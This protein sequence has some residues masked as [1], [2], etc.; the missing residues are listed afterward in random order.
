ML[1]RRRVPESDPQEVRTIVTWVGDGTKSV[2]TV[3]PD[4]IDTPDGDAQSK[5]LACLV[6]RF[7]RQKQ[8]GHVSF[9]RAERSPLAELA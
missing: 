5:G 7:K 3:D 9:W 2:F 4:R 8:A 6:E 1:D